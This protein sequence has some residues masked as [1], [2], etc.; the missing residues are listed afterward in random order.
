MPSLG[1]CEYNG[2]WQVRAS[3]NYL[4][5]GLVSGADVMRGRMLQCITEVFF[6]SQEQPVTRAT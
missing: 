2:V 4:G 6:I 3:V 1:I 5:V